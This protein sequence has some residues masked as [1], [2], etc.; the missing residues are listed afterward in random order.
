MPSPTAAAPPPAAAAAA[1]GGALEPPGRA[2][3][4]AAALAGFRGRAVPER[5][6]AGA[7]GLRA[8][9]LPMAGALLAGTE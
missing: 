6:R 9:P 8:A 4:L 3:S 5:L 1:P 2:L 7:R